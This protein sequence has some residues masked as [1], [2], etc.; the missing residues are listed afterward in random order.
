VRVSG[1]RPAFLKGA[2]AHPQGWDDLWAAFVEVIRE[3]VEEPGILRDSVSAEIVPADRY[4]PYSRVV[5]SRNVGIEGG[6]TDNNLE[7]SLGI[8]AYWA[9]VVDIGQEIITISGRGPS[10]YEHDP[11]QPVDAFVTQVEQHP[12]F[13]VLRDA[14]A[15]FARWEASYQPPDERD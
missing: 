8:G 10:S 12:V 5:L 13:A 2:G 1:L 14:D 9:P 7:A 11:N 6:M 4:T 3:P 15:H